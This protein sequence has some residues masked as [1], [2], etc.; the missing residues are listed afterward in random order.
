MTLA[1][2][3]RATLGHTG[4]ELHA[5]WATVLIYVLVNLGA[6]MRVAAAFQE[7]AIQTQTN[8]VAGAAWSAAFVTFAVVYGPRLIS[9]RSSRSL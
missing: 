1:V 2:M 5:G 8:I 7:A 6:L 4:L 9:P 3:T